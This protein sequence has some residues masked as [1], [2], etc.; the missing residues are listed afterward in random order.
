[1]LTLTVTTPGAVILVNVVSYHAPTPCN[2]FSKGVGAGCG[3]NALATLPEIGGG[4][5]QSNG[6]QYT[7]RSSV[8]ALPEIDTVVVGDF[9]YSMDDPWAEF[10]YQNLLTNY[11]ACVS[12]PN[13]LQLTTYAP[14]PSQ[15]GRRVSA[16]DNVFV[17]KAH[18]SFQPALT[19]ARRGVIDFIEQESST[20]G[21]A[22]GFT[23]PDIGTIVAWYVIH[24]DRYKKQHATRGISDHLPVWADF[25]IGG[26][27]TTAS[28]ILPTSG[29]E[30]NCLLHAI[31]GAA[32]SD[33]LWIDAD[34]AN[35]RVQFAAA[36][37]QYATNNA[38]PAAGV[39]APMRAS[40][41]SSM[42]NDFSDQP[43]IASALQ[44]LLANAV[45]PFL[46]AGFQGFFVRYVCNIADGRM[47]YVSEAQMIACLANL[48]VVLHY[49][50]RGSYQSMTFNP[51][52]G[53]PTTV[54][55]FHQAL[56]FYRW[57]PQP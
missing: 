6:R 27:D 7:Y 12:D 53:A 34:A 44:V 16:Y 9:N 54:H 48:T 1:M 40:I 3:I 28:Q 32:G 57:Q 52:A 15:P 51:G 8:M 19:F 21:Q 47:L 35:R 56:H 42:I 23:Q 31:F 17:L 49:T 22:I 55:I 36:L 39:L 24:Q 18:D 2:R 50:D 20:L 11:Q 26:K 38:I 10:T 14:S 25:T 41:L 30:N 43:A 33:G 46:V 29:A 37:A 5:Q 13:N 4:L 45:N